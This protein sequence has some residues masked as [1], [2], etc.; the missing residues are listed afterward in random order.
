VASRFAGSIL[1]YPARAAFLWYL[2]LILAGSLVLLHPVCRAPGR[3]PITAGDAIFTATSAACVTGLTVRSTG[4]DFSRVGQVVILVLIQLGGLG[5]MT[6]TTFI[7]LQLGGRETLRQRATIAE[8]LGTKQADD[9]RWVLRNVIVMF[10]ICEGAGFAI[11]AAR[12][13]VHQQPWPEAFWN[14]LFHAVSAFCNAGFALADDSLIPYQSDPVVTLTLAALIIFGG[15]GAPVLL[16]LRRHWRTPWR[17]KWQHLTLHTKLMLV[18][19]AFL[20]AVGTAAFLMF[21]GRNTLAGMPWDRRLLIAF[22][23]ATT[24]RTAGFNNVE[25]A[26]L[27]NATLFLTILLMA[28]GAGPCSTAGGFKVSTFMVLTLR[29]WASLRGYPQLMVFRRTVPRALVDFSLSTVLVFGIVAILALVGLLALEQADRPHTQ[30]HGLFLDTL[31][32]VVSALGTVGLSTGLTPQL[33]PEGRAFLIALM[34]I[35]RLGPITFFHVLSHSRQS[36]HFEYPKEDVLI[37]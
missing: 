7:S 26:A 12:H 17:E 25:V 28:V 30:S 37:G 20:L 8:T 11:L 18:G 4:H 14:A 2:V 33:G 35:G 6:V 19:T 31:F 36:Q 34:F 21:E 9:L 1:T 23:H 24:C 32:E 22:F 13:L 29:A 5:I 3:P 16:D 15:L 10:L 27:T